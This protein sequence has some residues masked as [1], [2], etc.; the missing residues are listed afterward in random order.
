MIEAHDALRRRGLSTFIF[1]NTNEMA[2][3]HIRKAF[4]F[5]AGFTGYILSYEHRAMKPEARLYKVLETMC[6]RR[7]REILYLDDRPENVDAGAARGWQVIL[8]ESPAQSLA[9]LRK[10]ELLDHAPGPFN[11]ST[12]ERKGNKGV[13]SFE[14]GSGSVS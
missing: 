8:H 4:P 13:A 1:S 10:L 3:R 7:G 11:R 2:V 12:E 9:A 14:P 6:G 5:F